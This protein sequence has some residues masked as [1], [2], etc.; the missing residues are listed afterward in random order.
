MYLKVN[1]TSNGFQHFL[2]LPQV[3]AEVLS[4]LLYERRFGPFYV[5]PVVA[6]IDPI[7]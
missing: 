7:R 1:V 3:F 5:N 2:L 4:N 6:G